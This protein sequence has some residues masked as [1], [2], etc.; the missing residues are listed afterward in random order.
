MCVSNPAFDA[1]TQLLPLSVQ[2]GV[3][4]QTCMVSAETGHS[5][6]RWDQAVE[7]QD[8]HQGREDLD[9]SACWCVQSTLAN[10]TL[11]HS[12]LG[13]FLLNFFCSFLLDLLGLPVGKPPRR[14]MCGARSAM[15]LEGSRPGRLWQG[16][17]GFCRR[18]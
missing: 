4:Y 11:E 3:F 12:Y 13:R 10:E 5:L 8:F 2:T 1:L 6:R 17:Q 14:S 7:G 18:G 16:Q 9:S 15:R